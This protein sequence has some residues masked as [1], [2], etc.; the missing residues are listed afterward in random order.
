MSATARN[1]KKIVEM[2]L[3][4]PNIDVNMKNKVYSIDIYEIFKK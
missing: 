2:L 1:N 4:I 3:K